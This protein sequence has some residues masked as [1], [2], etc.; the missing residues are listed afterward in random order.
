MGGI[1]REHL[2]RVPRLIDE[3]RDQT[4]LVFPWGAGEPLLNPDLYRMVRYCRDAGGH[5]SKGRC[6][7]SEAR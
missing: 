5:F 7:F 2:S 4:E 3:V 1:D 6:F